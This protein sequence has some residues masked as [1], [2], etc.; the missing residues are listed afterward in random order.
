[1]SRAASAVLAVLLAAAPPA[2]AAGEAVEAA[3]TKELARAT[4]ELKQEGLPAPYYVSLTAVDLESWEE[5]CLLGSPVFTG[6]YAQRLILPDVRV[7]SHELD[8]HPMAT[9]SGFQAR[10]ASLEEDE[11]ALR[12]GLWRQLDASYKTAAAD[13]LRK[14]AA[15]VSRGKAEYDTDDLSREAPRQRRAEPPASPWD[16]SALSALCRAS[17]ALRARPGLLSADSTVRLRRQWSRLRDSEGSAVDFGR[18]VVEIDLEA[19]ELSPDGTRLYASRRLTATRPEMLPTP[20]GLE[21][22]A[23]EMLADLEALRVAPTTSPFS[24]PALLDSSVAAAA[25]LAAGL[26]LSGEEQRNPQG[27]QTF[28][29]KLGKRVMPRGF[30]LVDDPTVASHAGRPLAGHYEFDDQGVPPRRVTL[31]DDGKL[32]GMLLSRY[33]VAGFPKSNGHGRASAGYT[34][35]G[36]PGSLFLSAKER[37]SEKELLELLRA[38]CRK[39]GKPYGIWVRR[40]RSFS[41]QQGT[42]GHAAI[43]VMAGLVYLVDAKTGA[44]TLV[45]DLDFVG[46]P[47][48]LLDNLRAAGDDAEATDLSY[49]APISVVTPSLLLADGELQ[50]AESRPEK[51]PVLPAPDAAQASP[52]GRRIVPTI[53]VV[54]HTQ[55]LRYVVRGAARLM[56]KFVIH[57]VVDSRQHLEG[58]D[59]FLDFKLAAPTLPQLGA[60]IRRLDAAVERLAAGKPF[61]KRAL[62]NPMTQRAYESAHGPGWPREP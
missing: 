15:R 45:R 9:P 58:E 23:G 59:A 34:P 28:R 8:N 18:D 43:R 41:Q 33:P 51:P 7:G 48:G 57:N 31:I 60:A 49:G 2:R 53:P 39:R 27:A 44:L 55:V 1:V 6:G 46:T 37:R 16:K 40:L 38:E 5:R 54:P 47:L 12:Y 62:T 50:R 21:R 42:S 35:V 13:F 26:R 19:S 10:A 29:D 4:S 17:R 3:L 14:Q 30:T 36:L 20:E 32:E 61:E 24:A 22:S 25:V 56:P 52:R 11:A